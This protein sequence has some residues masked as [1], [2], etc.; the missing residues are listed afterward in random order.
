MSSIQQEWELLG[1]ADRA[2]TTGRV[3][4]LR[5]WR[6]SGGASSR[7]RDTFALGQSGSRD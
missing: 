2:S 3:A 6:I 1:G 5:R 4:R 7:G